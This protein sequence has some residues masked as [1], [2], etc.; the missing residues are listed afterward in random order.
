MCQKSKWGMPWALKMSCWCDLAFATH[1]RLSVT[2]WDQLFLRIFSFKFVGSRLVEVEDF[3]SCRG[4]AEPKN[5][6][7]IHG[8]GS[9]KAIFL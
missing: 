3:I 8:N 6:Q 9:A 7:K 4:Q 1:Y 2:S 5:A